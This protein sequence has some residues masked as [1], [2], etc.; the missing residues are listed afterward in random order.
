MHPREI[1]AELTIND[2][3]QGASCVSV[4]LA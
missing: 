1:T 4:N 2:L 3:R